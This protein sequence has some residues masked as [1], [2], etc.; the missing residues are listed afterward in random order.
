M[1]LAISVSSGCFRRDITCWNTCG[2]FSVKDRYT[3]VVA[4][5]TAVL[6]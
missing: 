4:R 1:L 3:L 6:W 5:M 2:M